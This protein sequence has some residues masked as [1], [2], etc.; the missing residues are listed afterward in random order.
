MSEEFLRLNFVFGLW[1][2]PCVEH[3]HWVQIT[4]WFDDKS[5]KALL[6]LIPYFQR[7]AEGDPGNVV[8]FLRNNPPPAQYAALGTVTET[9]TAGPSSLLTMLIRHPSESS[10]SSVNANP[11]SSPS[12]LSLEERTRT[13]SRSSTTTPPNDSNPITSAAP[14][15]SALITTV[16]PVPSQSV[17]NVKTNN[18]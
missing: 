17:E 16:T 9:S 7:L 1:N 6:E 18:K 10:G 5:D 13:N 3:L 2:I 11:F 4:S 12:L 14:D 15:E 8:E